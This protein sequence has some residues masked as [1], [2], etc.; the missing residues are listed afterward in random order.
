MDRSWMEIRNRRH[1]LYI[2]GV[3]EF[4]KFAIDH[5][6]LGQTL[7]RCPCIRCNNFNKM[8]PDEAEEHM[9][10][11]GV[12]VGYSRWVYH[13]EE[14]DQVYNGHD[15]PT[16]EEES[17]IVDEMQEILD[18]VRAEQSTNDGTDSTAT[19]HGSDMPND[20][21]GEGDRFARLMRDA[22]KE[23]YPSCQKFSVLSFIVMLLHIK[24][25]SK[26]SNNSFDMLLKLLSDAF[27]HGATIPR[28]YKEAKKVIRDLGLHYE[29]THVCK[30]DCVLFWKEYKFEDKCPSCNTPRYKFQEG[31]R[32]RVPHKVLRYFPIKR[33]LRRFFGSRKIAADMTW[34]KDKR[35]EEEGVMRH[36]ADSLAWKEFDQKHE[37]FASDPRNVRLGLASDGF[38]PFGNMSTSYSEWPVILVPFNLP[39]WKCM[40][41]PFFMLSL[42]IPGRRSPGVDIDVFL[43][44]LIDELK[45]LW[46]IGI[47]TYDAITKQNFQLRAALLWTINDL[48]AYAYLS[49]WSTKGKLACPNCNEDA[50]HLY[51]HHGKKTCYM[52]HSRFLPADHPLRKSSHS[53]DGKDEDRFEPKMLSRE[54]ILAQLN[55]LVQAIFGKVDERGK[56]RKRSPTYLN[57]SKR[58]IFFELPYWKTL[59]IRHNLD[60]MHCEKNV[61]ESI[62]GTIM[63][64]LGKT[65]DSYKARLDM[66]D[67]EIRQE[68]HPWCEDGETYIPPAC[69]TLSPSEKKDFCEFLS[70]VKFPDNYASNISRCVTDDGRITGLKTHDCHVLLQRLLPIALR[71]YLRKDV[72]K[73][74]IE[75]SCFFKELT[76]KTL[77]LDVL[78][79]LKSDIVLILCKL[80]KIF[81]PAFFDVMIHLSIHLVEEAML[82]GPVQYR[83]MY[84][85]ERY[86]KVLKGYV[87]NKARPEGSIAEGYIDTKCMTFCSMYFEGIETRFNRVE[88][89]YEGDISTGQGSGLAIF[90][91]N[92]RGLGAMKY[93]ELNRNELAVAQA[94]VLNNCEEVYPYIEQHKEELR[95]QSNR[96]IEKRHQSEFQKWFLVLVTKKWKEG[97]EGVTNQLLNLARGPDKRVARYNGCL[98]KGF[99]FHTQ[100]HE[101]HRKSQNSGVVV[102][103]SHRGEDIDFYGV[104]T[105]VIELSYLGGNHIMLFRC[106]WMLV[107]QGEY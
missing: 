11:W 49:G 91:Q 65:K 47:D 50:S 99:R 68:L 66:V 81:P 27:P 102:K 87:C 63:N 100:E 69:Y 9:Y 97:S 104:V 85:F 24:I 67:M 76:S 4:I 58:S 96:N 72:S 22:E 80:E 20:F 37:S 64:L 25:I 95:R 92:A 56:K 29:K 94:Y 83:W 35:I 53:F 42:L 21:Q 39:P 28:T 75:L 98:V 70:N 54:D 10:A 18:D 84:Q 2:Q 14:F 6:P 57:W 17:I 82:G 40:K 74:L 59:K 36:P 60:T 89:N 30:N 52:G 78:K 90:S 46:T 106:D 8:T 19:G 23:L 93:D 105:D 1:P 107:V 62:I 103:G 79:R 16:I 61:F 51:L 26:W 5:M 33:K 45:E 73:T 31:K 7:I 48:P 38:N 13:G 15:S 44:P 86:M 71:G 101:M 41:D 34:H 77:H 32:N 3:K 12:V 88:R 55:N 43:R